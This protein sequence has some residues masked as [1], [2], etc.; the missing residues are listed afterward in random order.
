MKK[1]EQDFLLFLLLDIQVVSSAINQE[2]FFVF[3]FFGS[4]VY[5]SKN[6][7]HIFNFNATRKWRGHYGLSIKYG[8]KRE[9]IFF[10]RFIISIPRN[11]A[12]NDD[13]IKLETLF[14]RKYDYC[15]A[16]TN[17]LISLDRI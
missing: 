15:V 16:R 17:Q 6:A 5:S 2:L 1:F 11:Y 12:L 3:W 4:R 14:I 13:I 10:V 9:F 8:F 7:K